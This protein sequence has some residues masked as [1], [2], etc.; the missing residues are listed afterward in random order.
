[1]ADLSLI[2]CTRVSRDVQGTRSGLKLS[3]R[4]VCFSTPLVRV[5]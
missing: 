2:L 3:T 4:A 1:M 5:N